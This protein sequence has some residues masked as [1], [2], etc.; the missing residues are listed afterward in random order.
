MSVLRIEVRRLSENRRAVGKDTNSPSEGLATFTYGQPIAYPNNSWTA[1][2]TASMV[3]D[4]QPS[5]DPVDKAETEYSGLSPTVHSRDGSHESVP[6]SGLSSPPSDLSPIMSIHEA[7]NDSSGETDSENGSASPG[8]VAKD[9]DQ[10]LQEVAENISD[11]GRVIVFVGA[12]I[13]TNCGVPVSNVLC[14]SLPLIN[15]H[16]GL[17]IG[18]W[19]PQDKQRIV[20]DRS[21]KRRRKEKRTVHLLK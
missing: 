20:R 10:E 15:N 1:V 7:S 2:N 11:A 18:T 12:G 9:T 13:S 6:S 14:S 3:V 16:A 19:S 4:F 21:P 8:V 5:C 17:S